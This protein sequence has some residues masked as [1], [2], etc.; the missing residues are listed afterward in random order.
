MILRGKPAWLLG[1]LLAVPA[2]ASHHH[3]LLIG[4]NKYSRPESEVNS[5][6]WRHQIPDLQGSENDVDHTAAMLETVYGWDAAD[7]TQLKTTRATRANIFGELDRIADMSA[8][9]DTVFFFYSGHGS[10]VKNSKTHKIT[11]PSEDGRSE[12]GVSNTIVPSDSLDGAPDITDKELAA[13]FNKLLDRKVVLTA[14]FDSCFSGEIARG[15]MAGFRTKYA[16]SAVVEVPNVDV[17]EADPVQVPSQR[18]A[19]I[20]SAARYYEPAAEWPRLGQ[21]GE[22][23]G[24]FAYALTET[25]QEKHG[26]ASVRDLFAE[27]RGRLK[28]MLYPQEP[29]Y[30]GAD[31]RLNEGLLG[32]P[33]ASDSSLRIPVVVH[34]PDE[35]GLALLQGGAANGLRPGAVLAADLGDHKARASV[36]SADLASCKAKYLD[37]EPSVFC[38]A[39]TFRVESFP[40]GSPGKLTVCIP[41]SKLSLDEIVKLDG[42]IQKTAPGMVVDP[43]KESADAWATPGSLGAINLKP[44]GHPF[45]ALPLAAN[46]AKDLQFGTDGSEL[47]GEANDVDQG[48]DY[49]LSGSVQAGKLRYAWIAPSMFPVTKRKDLPEQRSLGSGLSS[50]PL[51]T[52]WHDADDPQLGQELEMDARKLCSLRAWALLSSQD[53][54]RFPCHLELIDTSN[55]AVVESGSTVEGYPPQSERQA[56]DADRRYQLRIALNPGASGAIESR[57]V[58][59]MDVDPQW[60]GTL[61]Y[62]P[63][64]DAPPWQPKVG[65]N[66]LILGA[67]FR[68][69]TPLGIEHFVLV[70][71][72]TPITS[73]PTELF[74]FKGFEQRSATPDSNPLA[75]LL[76]QASSGRRSGE[77]E[78]VPTTWSVQSLL[79]RSAPVSG[80]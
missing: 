5:K 37:G 53:D 80:K 1:I 45:V 48:A 49:V 36:V 47:I 64:G 17:A 23:R 50:M 26:A 72:A 13:E 77:N 57:Y 11:V 52:T 51:E 14:L 69:I 21:P 40:A 22:P 65:E 78:P 29:V 15:T 9:G 24:A 43:G 73:D 35:S 66:P 4:I 18:G 60:S 25:V 46:L 54:G 39:P 28:A 75:R 12:I 74:N 68:F 62:P 58:Y 59:V 20:L 70:T 10:T 79:V 32:E 16:P 38:K 41:H 76:R 30:E 6:A 3:A 31:E 44:A 67:P 61:I 63:Q 56:Q 33:V 34:P 19:L 8:P 27:S 55:G 2:H 71:S 7:I 42:E